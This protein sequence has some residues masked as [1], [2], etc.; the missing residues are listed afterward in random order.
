MNA[1]ELRFEPRT[2]FP[3]MDAR[4]P[5]GDAL[6]VSPF[7]L[8]A[9]RDPDTVG[10]AFDAGINFFFLTADMH[11][12]IYEASRRGLAALF[13]RGGGVRDR[14]VVAGVAYVTQPEFC[15]VPFSEVVASVPGL[16][17]L[18]VTIAGGSYR[19]DFAPRAEQ[20]ALHRRRGV[21]AFGTSFHDRDMAAEALRD[22]RV[23]IGFIRYNALHRGAESDLFSQLPR[24]R[25]S[26]LY[27]FTSTSGF[28][29]PERYAALGLSADHWQPTITDHY[30]FVLARSE[31]DGLLCAPKTPAE[32]EELGRVLERGPLTDEEM[33]YIRDLS[34][35]ARGEVRLVPTPAADPTLTAP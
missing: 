12:P 18:E 20:Y 10:A 32:I 13:A 30:R 24:G 17:R 21:R 26:L 5:L 7:C 11:W 34:D 2:R 29:P 9:V 28:I 3:R 27:N 1:S 14:V 8:G 4:L 22:D 25:R 33:D 23:D 16:E 19:G 6:L 15:H 35:L 31:I